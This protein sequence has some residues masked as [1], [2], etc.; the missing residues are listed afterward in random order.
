MSVVCTFDAHDGCAVRAR[1]IFLVALAAIAVS[2]AEA[3]AAETLQ[4]GATAA[5][6][7]ADPA[8]TNAPRPFVFGD[9]DAARD[10]WAAEAQYQAQ[11]KN[12]L[13]AFGWEVLLPGMGN[14]YANETE[15]AVL[16]WTFLLMGGYFLADGYGLICET[17]QSS[18]AKCG[19]K[20]FFIVQGWVLV[21][22]SRLFGLTSAPANVSRNN[23]ALRASLGLDGP[24]SLGIAPWLAPR[25][26]GLQLALK[27]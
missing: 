8:S 26:G 21:I 4:P 17:F 1:R 24:I 12:P 14:V 16:T 2:A 15:E 22:G 7:V 25:D 11:R 6:T 20:T 19:H 10:L 18:T 13:V 3:S 9:S 23:R 27:F 5:T